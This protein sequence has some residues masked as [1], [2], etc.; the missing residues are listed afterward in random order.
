MAK[1]SHFPS[2]EEGIKGCSYSNCAK[3]KK[4]EHP[5]APSFEEGEEH[6]LTPSYEEG[7]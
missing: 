5:L 6:P 4:G 2:F 1:Q 3:K 7:E